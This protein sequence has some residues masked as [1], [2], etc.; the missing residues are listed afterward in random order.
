MKVK[1]SY[2][3]DIAEVKE[4]LSELMLQ[5]SRALEHQSVLMRQIAELFPLEQINESAALAVMDSIRRSLAQV[6]QSL[7]ESSAILYGYNEA[8]NG[9][10]AASPAEQQQMSQP[11]APPP[12][13]PES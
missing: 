13:Q 12:S 11:P 2:S 5:S 6:D 3:I 7:V 9:N 10:G 1:L 4:K 8:L